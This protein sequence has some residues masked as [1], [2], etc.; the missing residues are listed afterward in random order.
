MAHASTHSSKKHLLNTYYVPGIVI[1]TP[2]T[3]STAQS[4]TSPAACTLGKQTLPWCQ[5]IQPT[6]RSWRQFK[7]KANSFTRASPDCFVCEWGPSPSEVYRM[8]RW[9]LQRGSVAGA[10]RISPQ[11]AHGDQR[12]A[13]LGA[14]E[15]KQ[16]GKGW[17]CS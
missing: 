5:E 12:P 15:D 4:I 16:D 14:L 2:D 8:G 6:A 7:F 10:P 1:G 13:L 3:E 9:L 17:C 11:E